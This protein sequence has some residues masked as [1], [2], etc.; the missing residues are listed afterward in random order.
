MGNIMPKA[1]RVERPAKKRIRS[2]Y[3]TNTGEWSEHKKLFL[4]Q[5]RKCG[6]TG[7]AMDETDTIYRKDG[8]D[9]LA[10]E[11]SIIDAYGSTDGWTEVTISEPSNVESLVEDYDHNEVW[12][13]QVS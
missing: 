11:S 12:N 6:L 4:Q 9:I 2:K 13:P 5:D 10:L 3:Q 7:T 8:D 1:D